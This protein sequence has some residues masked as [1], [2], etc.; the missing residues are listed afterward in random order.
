MGFFL[1]EAHELRSSARGI[2][3]ILLGQRRQAGQ[4]SKRKIAGYAA[5]DRTVGAPLRTG[6]VYRP[7][8]A[9]IFLYLRTLASHQTLSQHPHHGRLAQQKAPSLM[10]SQDPQPTPPPPLPPI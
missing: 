4:R 3:E 8:A 9:G 2:R 1:G 10:P 5:A 7:D 6:S